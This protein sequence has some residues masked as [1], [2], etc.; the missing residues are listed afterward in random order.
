MQ[1][2]CFSFICVHL[3]VHLWL[4]FFFFT[5]RLKLNEFWP[6]LGLVHRSEWLYTSLAVEPPHVIG[7]LTGRE[8][9]PFVAGD[10]LARA[11]NERLI[12]LRIMDM[13]IR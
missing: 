7:E 11:E 6:Y 1:L 13:R 8:Y 12:V 4:K 10:N 3:I 9:D 5:L 2:N